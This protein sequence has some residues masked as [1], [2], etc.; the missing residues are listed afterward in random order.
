VSKEV[1]RG[2]GCLIA[3]PK[4]SEVLHYVDKPET[5][6]SDL[7]SCGIYIFRP[8]IFEEFKQHIANKIM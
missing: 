2:Y 4:N 7:V 8:E 6:L 3:D 1:S 5:F